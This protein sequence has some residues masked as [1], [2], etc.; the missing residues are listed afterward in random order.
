[1]KTKNKAKPL[2][3]PKQKDPFEI[4]SVEISPEKAIRECAD[5]I[6]ESGAAS[7]RKQIANLVQPTTDSKTV[8]TYEKALASIATNAWKAKSRLKDATSV[9]DGGI[10]KKIDGDL[11]RILNVIEQGLGWEIKGHTGKDYD[12]GMAL[13]VVTTQP[14]AGIHRERVIETIKPTIYDKN[15]KNRIIQIGAVVVATPI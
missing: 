15:D 11:D 5:T 6:F 4:G 12:Y 14:T 7:A 13:K 8:E 3:K 10:L 9:E 2:K 1:M